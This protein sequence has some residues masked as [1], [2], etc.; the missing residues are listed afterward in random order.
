VFA[1][2]INANTDGA[3]SFMVVAANSENRRSFMEEN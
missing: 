2:K 3:Q 1:T